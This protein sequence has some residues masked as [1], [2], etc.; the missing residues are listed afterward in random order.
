MVALVGTE[1]LYN[2]TAS[3]K[4]SPARTFVSNPV[5]GKSTK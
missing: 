5:I 4:L 1:D 2:L 3:Q